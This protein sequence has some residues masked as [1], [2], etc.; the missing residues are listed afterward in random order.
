MDEEEWMR[1]CLKAIAANDPDT[2]T[3]IILDINRMLYLKQQ[4]L[5]DR[6]IHSE[7]QVR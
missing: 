5:K 3:Q 4:Q 6:Q 2:L 1:L 7:F